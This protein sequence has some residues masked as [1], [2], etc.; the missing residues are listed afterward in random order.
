[1]SG[2]LTVAELI[3]LLHQMPMDLPVMTEGCDC[4]GEARGVEKQ[5]DGDGDYVLVTR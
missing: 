5:N 4:D 1:M 2:Q 3:E